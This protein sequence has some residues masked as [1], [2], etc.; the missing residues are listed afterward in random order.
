MGKGKGKFKGFIRKVGNVFPDVLEV[1][2]TAITNPIEAIS[3]VGEMLSEKAES[4]ENAKLL[5]QEYDLNVKQWRLEA[6]EA[7]VK[8]RKSARQL[9]ENDSM[10]QKIL[11]GVFTCGYFAIT[12]VLIRHFF[13]QG[14]DLADYELGFISTLFGAMSAKVNTIIDFFFG[15]SVKGGGSS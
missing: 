8:D 6:F 4:D 11:A 1:A 12:G 9:F 5:L 2:T 14:G 13:I 10:T 15:G 7:E 3:K